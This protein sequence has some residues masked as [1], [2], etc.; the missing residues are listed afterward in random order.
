MATKRKGEEDAG[1]ERH[2]MRIMPLGAGNEVGRSC[3]ILKFQGKTIML[4]CGVHPGY[5]GHGSLPYFDSVEAEEIDL[6]LITHFHIDHVAG[7]P[8]FTEK[9]GFKGRIFMTHPTKA[10]MQM[11]LRDFLRVSNI[12][13][14][15]QIYDDKDLERCVAKVEIIDFHQ[16]K[17]INGIKFTPYNAGHVLGACMFL[18]EIGGVKVLYTGDYSLENDRH[19]MAAEI[20][21]VSPDV[22]I[23]EST[24]GVQVHQSVVERE[25]RFT[26]QVESV[27][28]R[29]GRCLIPVFALGRTQELLLILD[30]HWKAHPDLQNVP[31]YFAS[32]LAAKALRVYQTY[33]NMMNERIRK[34]I[35]ISNPFQFEFISNL[36]S[37]KDFDDTGPSVVMASP[38]MLQSGVSRQLFE[39]WCS[40]KKNECLIP[41]Y[42]VEGTLAKKILSLPTEITS[43]DGRLLP[44]NCSVEYISFS[45]HADFVGTSGFIEK[46]A[47][48]HIVLVHGEKTEMMRL[49]AA[50]HKKFHNP[51]VYQPQIYTPANTV[52][53]VLEFRGEKVA[54]AIGRMATDLAG[55]AKLRSTEKKKVSGLLVE[56]DF[57]THVMHPDDLSEYTTNL[58][59]GS[60]VQKQ[61]V[62]FVHQ[63]FDVLV[64]LVR[65][66]YAD[67]TSTHD[68]I[69]VGKRVMVTHCP[70][71]KVVIEWTADP[72]ADMI[73]DS[74]VALTMHAQAS[75]ASFKVRTRCLARHGAWLSLACA[76]CVGA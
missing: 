1:D 69:I 33:I 2:V 24:Y 19:L 22:L 11:M 45:A 50:L 28:R 74:I 52:D 67:L 37:L 63:P 71:D 38:G 31:I 46:V 48:P 47:P 68:T 42:V 29:G 25:G 62:P 61:H 36:K 59:V 27:V 4:D 20:P 54:K 51:K 70:P 10:V 17:M 26:G 41:G 64:V 44:M 16:E 43:M 15:D 55:H 3:I 53:V 75:P 14:E 57:H 72:S 40:D 6:L 73:A 34:Q 8:H 18:I 30:E 35:A 9:T 66:M 13:V 5:S 32:K 60:I 76:I 39:R 7:L 21:G 12:S 65:Q 56:H 23:V 49:K 58:L